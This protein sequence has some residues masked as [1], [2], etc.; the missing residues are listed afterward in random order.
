MKT[1]LFFIAIVTV[2]YPCFSQQSL[3]SAAIQIKSAILAAPEDK[4]D[5]CTVYG[6]D[7]DK[8]L[9]LLMQAPMSLFVSLTIRIS[10]VS[11]LHVMLKTWS[12]L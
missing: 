12:H 4:K 9:I 8:Q 7:A 5:S 3:P 1:I 10:R 2:G 6:Y 11:P